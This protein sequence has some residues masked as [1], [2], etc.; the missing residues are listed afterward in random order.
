MI[1]FLD[2]YDSFV[3]NLY[4]LCLLYTSVRTCSTAFLT[5]FPPYLFGSPSRSSNASNCPVEAPLGA[6][7]LPIVPS[8]KITSASTVGFPLE[9]KISRAVID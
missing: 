8:A 9:S 2:N 5:P 3:Y 7:P 1:L 6:A 4:Q